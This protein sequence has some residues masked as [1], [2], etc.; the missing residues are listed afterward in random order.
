MWALCL[1]ADVYSA[2]TECCIYGFVVCVQNTTK[3]QST[4]S[5]IY[6][7]IFKTILPSIIVQFT[8]P[9][10]FHFTHSLHPIY[11]MHSIHNAV[12]T[13]GWHYLHS[14]TVEC[15]THLNLTLCIFL[16]R[17]FPLKYFS[18]YDYLCPSVFL[19]TCVQAR[20]LYTHAL[21]VCSSIRTSAYI[22]YTQFICSI[23]KAGVGANVPSLPMPKPIGTECVRRQLT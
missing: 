3:M 17:L 11:A 8:L 12:Q 22:R 13:L 6:K 20:N 4:V 7:I 10:A 19:F 15:C 1:C 18:T 14:G 2:C 21:F 9:A 5:C 23:A 16:S